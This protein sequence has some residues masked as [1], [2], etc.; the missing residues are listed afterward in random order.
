M[1]IYA[2]V[3]SSSS[4]SLPPTVATQYNTQDG[5]ASPSANIL[6][7]N[8]IDSTENNSNGIITKGGIAGTGTVNEV[9]V[10]LT[11]RYSATLTTTDDTQTELVSVPIPLSPAVYNFIGTVSFFDV[12][13]SLG[14]VVNYSFAFRTTPALGA[15]VQLTP[16]DQTTQEDAAIGGI[17]EFQSIGA[18]QIFHILVTG[19][20]ATTFKWQVTGTYTVVS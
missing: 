11:N 12:T 3:L 18:S 19:P 1:G 2:S 20:A 16:L 5:N 7:I 9:D 17:V 14:S 8:G 4:G 13:N 6:I 10:V 15:T